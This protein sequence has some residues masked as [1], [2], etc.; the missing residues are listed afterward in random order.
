MNP[1]VV[2]AVR[3]ALGGASDNLHRARAA[4]R[5]LGADEMGQLY[6]QSGETRA[7]IVAG[8]EREVERWQKALADVGGKP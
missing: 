4:F 8:Y 6:G 3:D 5:G 2:K 1:D 7:E